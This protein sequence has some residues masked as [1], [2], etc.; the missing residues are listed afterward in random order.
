MTRPFSIQSADV[1]KLNDIQLTQLL[2]ELLH[3]EAFRFGLAQR[4]VEVALNITTGDGGEDGRISWQEGPESTDYIPNRLTLFQNK[5]T[6]MGPTAYGKELLTKDGLL[7]P[8]VEQ[9]LDVGGSYVVFTTQALNHNEKQKRINEMRKVLNTLG[10]A[11]YHSCDIKI[12]DSAQIAGWANLYIPAIVAIQNWIGRPVERGLKTFDLWSKYEDIFRLPFTHVVS[13]QRI[14]STLKSELIKPRS[15]FRIM[16]LSGLGKTRTAYQVFCEDDLLKNLVVYVD[17]N[18]AP[19]IDAL[20]AD[21][22]SSS[23]EAIVVVD[24]CEYRLHE[25]LVRE[26]RREDSR[27]SLLSLDYNFDTVSALTNTFTLEPLDDSELLQ[28]LSPSYKDLLPDLDRIA[29]FAQGFPQMAVL[30]S[31][32]RL[33]E[34]PRIGELSGDDLANKLLW[35]RGENENTDYLKILQVCS[36]F[37]VFGIEKETEC[38][39]E[40]ISKI[41]GLEIDKVFECIQKYS[42]RG[43]IDRRGRYGQVVPKPLAIRLASQWWTNTRVEKQKNFI[44]DV[45]DGMLQ[46][47]CD[48][49]EKLDFHPNVKALTEK[50]CGPQGPFGQAEVILSDRGSRLFRAFVN[51]N[52]DAISSALYRVVA[53][54]SHEQI[55]TIEDKV[56]RNLVWALEMLCFHSNLFEES[57]WVLFLLAVV[58]NETWNNNATGIFSQLFQVQLSGTSA[59]P[60]VRFAL[61]RRALDLGEEQADLVILKALEQAINYRGGRRTVGAEYQGTK[62]P[63]QEWRPTIWQEIFD[64]WQETFNILLEMLNRGPV[65]KERVMDAIGHSIRGF[66]NQGRIEMLDTAIR[67]VVKLNG[68]YWPAALQSIKSTLE[69]DVNNIQPEGLTAL[70]TW[71]ELLN[72]D[73]A[74]LEEKLKILVINPPWEHREDESGNYIDVAAENAKELATEVSKNIDAFFGNIPML[75]EGEQKQAYVFGCQLVLEVE[76]YAGLLETVLNTL[77]NIETPNISFCLGLLNGVFQ[78]SENSWQSYIEQIA[79]DK[80]LVRYYP[81]FIRTGKIQENHLEK[82]LALIKIGFLPYNSPLVLSY[83]RVTD[84]ISPDIIAN[85]CLRL[86]QFNDI[87]TWTALNVMFMYCLGNEAKFEATREA[88]KT[89]VTKVSFGKGVRAD[90]SDI[91]NWQE[92][93]KK[94]L[95]SE[96]KE[97]T[98]AICKQVLKATVD[99]FDHG[100]IWDSIKPL[101]IDIM[102]EQGAELWPL[103]GDAIVSANSTQ[104]Y[105][106]QQLLER[107]NGLFDRLPSVLSVLP[108]EIIVSWCQENRENG[109]QF[110]ARCINI[111]KPVDNQQQPTDL[112]IALLENFGDDEYVGSALSANLG[113]RSTSGS[114]LPYLESDKRALKP[115]LEHS[116][117]IV[118]TWVKNEISYLNKRIKYESMLEDERELGIY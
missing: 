101:L 11:Y 79:S 94:L 117:N 55:F 18:H 7:K 82:L 17:A 37:D 31:E 68:R 28:L 3:A 40:F 89:L 45:P 27:I 9:G 114:L 103:F 10:K 112:F 2:K 74:A 58:E 73:S 102:Q 24:N 13:R 52:P 54:L 48:Q 60:S 80:I 105:W 72:P 97:F 81:D 53:P 106:L 51:V 19:Q 62:A 34:D 65:Q 118:R 107:A 111:F 108:T 113:L 35:S 61:L 38:Q 75:L 4:S 23:L 91:Y 46:G 96:D 33:I 104:R 99:G 44:D 85:F 76:T 83:G 47:F 84:G 116:N 20:V 115:L 30:L 50:L 71:Q 109:P 21:W 93:T 25:S 6:K 88:L 59:E 69:Y 70:G 12:Y 29:S 92:I 66:V 63:L 77:R 41:V 56:R 86:S 64:Y 67:R 32:A 15:C 16:G 87:A 36:L 39:L 14:I 8:I 22:V 95:H 100:S 78:K 1:N 90:H 110:V 43:L 98:L 5:A 42:R 57:A 49:V 26:V